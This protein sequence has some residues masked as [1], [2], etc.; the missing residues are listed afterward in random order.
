MMPRCNDVRDNLAAYQDG[1]LTEAERATIKA[2][3]DT[4][5]DC[6]REAE[7]QKAI[8]A[9]LRALKEQ[10]VESRPPAHIWANARAAWDRQDKARARR[11]QFRFALVAASILL[12]TFGIV[13]ANRVQTTDYPTA[14]VLRDF[15]ALLKNPPQ[16]ALASNDA[17]EAA[18]WLR[19]NLKA[20]VPPIRL[21]LSGAELQGADVL[22]GTT[23]PLGRLLYRTPEGLAAVYVAPRG[24]RFNGLQARTKDGRRFFVSDTSPDIGLYGWAHG[25]VG[26]GLVLLQPIG[27]KESLAQEAQRAIGIPN[28]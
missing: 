21:A 14:I 13:W 3:L 23:P 5:A 22:S 11:L 27:P 10:A 9:H 24:T 4:C 12:L 7:A 19:Q 20:D 28:P 25:M 8:K 15:R 2:H 16:T 18:V 17:D 6:R 1:E 26:Y